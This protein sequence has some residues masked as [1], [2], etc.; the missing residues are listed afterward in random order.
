MLS[1]CFLAPTP[2]NLSLSNS[3]CPSC[4]RSVSRLKPYPQAAHTHINLSLP[5][6]ET[7]ISWLNWLLL[8]QVYWSFFGNIVGKPSQD[9]CFEFISPWDFPGWSSSDLKCA[10]AHRFVS[11]VSGYDR[12]LENKLVFMKDFMKDFTPTLSISELQLTFSDLFWGESR[13]NSSM[14]ETSDYFQARGS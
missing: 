2:L 11:R 6:F 8:R 4:W 12:S 1:A 13:Q 5:L 9:L 7:L 14:K 3:R 10:G